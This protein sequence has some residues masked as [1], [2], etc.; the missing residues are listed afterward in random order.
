M[1]NIGYKINKW[2]KKWQDERL[3]IEYYKS[4]SQKTS[5]TAGL[6]KNVLTL[7]ILSFIILGKSKTYKMAL[8]GI[9][10][11]VILLVVL[12]YFRTKKEN[13]RLKKYCYKIVAEKEYSKRLEN[14]TPD[15]IIRLLGNEIRNR[16]QVSD[17]KIVNGILEG[18]IHNRKLAVVYVEVTGDEEH[19]PTRELMTVIRRCISSGIEELRIFT[20]GKYGPSSANLKQRYNLNLRLYNAEKLMDI[21][22]NTPIFPTLAEVKKLIDQEKFQRRKKLSLI[23]KEILEKKNFFSYIGYSIVLLL[24]SWY[25]IGIKYLNFMA[26][27]ILLGFAM[28]IVWKVIKANEGESDTFEKEGF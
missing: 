28:A 20:N 7:L 8:W 12:H 21:L 14:A 4:I 26:G 11:V 5:Y 13:L 22:K 27:L 2:W 25:G 23:K 9:A 6:L 15:F 17:F 1:P 19:V 18:I 3:S 10:F 16:F 24:M